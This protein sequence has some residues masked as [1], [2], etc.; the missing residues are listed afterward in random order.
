[1]FKCS[2]VKLNLSSGRASAISTI[3]FS[4]AVI[5]RSTAEATVGGCDCCTLGAL[6]AA[7]LFVPCG[8]AATAKMGAANR[9]RMGIGFMGASLR[10]LL[11]CDAELFVSQRDQR[12]DA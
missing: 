6:A 3:C 1:M 2:G 12:I 8:R 10:N 7:V 9:K 4:I 5:S 11:A